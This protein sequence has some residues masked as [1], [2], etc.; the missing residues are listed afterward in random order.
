MSHKW[1]KHR[2]EDYINNNWAKKPKI[3]E[4]S[5]NLF[6]VNLIVVVIYI[7]ILIN[8]IFVF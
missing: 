4:T 1:N 6:A 5:R 8:E 3:W 2:I 7:V